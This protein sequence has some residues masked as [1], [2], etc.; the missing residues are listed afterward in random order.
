MTQLPVGR[1]WKTLV[2]SPAKGCLVHMPSEAWSFWWQSNNNS[3]IL[4]SSSESTISQNW[5]WCLRLLGQKNT[6]C[7]WSLYSQCTVTLL[8]P[9]TRTELLRCHLY[10]TGLRMGPCHQSVCHMTTYRVINF[11]VGTSPCPS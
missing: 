2:L 9:S 3:G 4:Y 7:T 1:R 8:E 10:V 6:S 11:T 5:H